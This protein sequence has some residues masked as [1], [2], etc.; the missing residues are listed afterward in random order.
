MT[1]EEFHRKLTAILSADVQGYSRLMGEDED[2][3]IR[4]LTAYRALMSSLIQKHRGHVVDTPGDNLLAEFGSVMDAVRCAVEIQEELRIRNEELPE[5]RK[6]H[7]RIGINLGDI[8]EDG[9][10]I[11]GDGVNIAARVEGMAEGG[12]ICISGTVYDAIR[13]KLS[14]SYEF[15]GEHVVKNIKELV[16]IY[17]IR[18]EPEA[19]SAV[20]KKKK[21][22]LRRWQWAA[23]SVVAILILG[24]VAYIVF[25]KVYIDRRAT[26]TK[27]VSTET[28]QLP[29]V[30]EVKEGPKTIAVI[31]FVNRS[32]EKDQEY[33]VDGLSDEIITRLS[34]IA[35]LQVT[36]STS[37]FTFKGSDKTIQEIAEI[38]GRE[39]ILEG[40]VRKVGNAL[41]ITAQ[42]IHAPDDNHLWSEIYDRELKDIFEIQEDIATAVANELKATLG[43][44]KSLKQLGGTDNK[45]AY[46][47]YLVAKGQ[48]RKATDYKDW[49]HVLKLIEPAITLDPEFALAWDLKAKA[50]IQTTIYGPARQYT[51]ARDAAL[52]AAQ[53]AIELEPNLGSAHIKMGTIKWSKGQLIDAELYY[54]KALEITH[55][56][57]SGDDDY[58]VAFYNSVGN[59]KRAHELLELIRRYDPLHLGYRGHDILNLVFLGNIQG[60]EEEYEL[61]RATFGDFAWHDQAITWVRIGSGKVI[62]SDEIVSSEPI[63]A[64]A[65]MYFGSPGKVLSEL[66]RYDI[67]N[68]GANISPSLFIFAAYFNDP[69]FAMDAIEKRLSVNHMGLFNVWLPVMH[70]V[71]QLPGFKEFIGEI[72]LVDYWNKFG[73]P[74]TNICRPLDSGNFVCD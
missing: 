73:W 22:G 6:M 43:I 35:D 19:E 33:F 69:E 42:L 63:D 61:C 64:L 13:N 4:T 36:S 26:E 45:E 54:D 25:D 17:R 7:F 51:A 27:I 55:G 59:F 52:Q 39:Y 31:P 38:L 58:I 15:M 49:D 50:H 68:L 37:S 67:D 65:K 47:L 72:G 10:H 62:Y 28:E 12:G 20:K 1:T 40:S 8:I 57:L 74:D 60:A 23:I 24:A 21:G 34:Q 5:N 46:E 11:Y 3:T 66:R 2:S 41:R 53:K 30:S 71:R 48:S 56:S 32:S 18:V 9:D 70:E 16:R 29:A 14:M 44:G